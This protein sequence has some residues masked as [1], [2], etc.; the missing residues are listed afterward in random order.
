MDKPIVNMSNWSLY[1][2][3]EHYSLSGTADYHPRFGNHSYVSA[4]SSLKDYVFDDDVLI[5]ETRNTIYQ[6]PLKYIDT[7]PYQN[8]NPAY[9]EELI[10]RADYSD[11]P[12]D[13][14][15]SASAR[16]AVGKELEDEFVQHI[17]RLTVD[18]KKELEKARQEEEEQMTAIAGQYEDCI[19]I[20]VSNISDGDTLAYHIGGEK[21]IISPSLHV[22][23]I[24]DSVLYIQ[25]EVCEIDFRYFP[26]NRGEDVMES[27]SWSENIKNVVLKNVK[28]VPIEFNK[29]KVLPGETKIFAR[30]TYYCENVFQ[31]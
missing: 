2:Y 19:Y 8:V 24:Q 6:C 16:L 25:Y 20:E 4:T 15:I 10:H 9:K 23:I 1:V 30:E 18:G 12:L 3:A 27:Y 7:M 26:D 13:K 5:Y 14:I 22:G 28:D 17:L 11:S 29:E 21:G 31:M